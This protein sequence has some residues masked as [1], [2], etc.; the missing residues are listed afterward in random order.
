MSPTVTGTV[1]APG[2]PLMLGRETA[3][4]SGAAAADSARFWKP[5]TLSYAVEFQRPRSER[6][7]L[8]TAEAFAESTRK[9][10]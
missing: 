3:T 4:A 7:V 5:F 2:V 6:N 10:L 8:L 9:K 1:I